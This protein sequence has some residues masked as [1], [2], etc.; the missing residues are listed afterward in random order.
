TGVNPA[1]GGTLTVSPASPDGW[2]TDAALV[3]LRATPAEGFGFLNW[4]GRRFANLHGSSANP[5]SFRITAEDL[6]YV[7]NFSRGVLTTIATNPPHLAITV[8]GTIDRA[9]RNFEWMAG[10]SHTIAV[11]ESITGTTR[12]AF[13][14]WSDGGAASHAVTAGAEAT[15]TANFQA[16]H[17]LLT[18]MSGLGTVRL[19]PPS[20]DGYYDEGAVVT[21]TAAAGER[22]AF[23]QWSGD[24]AGTAA[25]QTITMN[26]QKRVV[27]AFGVPGQISG[28]GVLSAASF[29]PGSIA[30][31]QILTL[32]GL[33][34]GPDDLALGQFDADGK[35]P[36]TLGGTRA[37]IDGVAAPL[38]YATKNQVAAIVPYS[39]A[40][41]T[42]VVVGLI[43]TGQTVLVFVGT[44]VAEAAPGIFAANAAGFGQVLA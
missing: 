4:G 20:T 27:A 15:Y 8:D 16:R 44:N 42:R 22:F 17:Q 7:A 41:K 24:L 2:Y 23:D 30:P 5:L 10:S 26:E 31:G 11:A 38:W 19:T 25:E 9:P 43:R 33:G 32:F 12:Y 13:R 35:L 14:D 37:F 39:V 6:N 1:A 18:A 28:S 3:E 21:V 36:T 34:V 29:L 40:G